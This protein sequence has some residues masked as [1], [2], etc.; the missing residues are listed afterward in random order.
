[1]GATV[2]RVLSQGRVRKVRI[3][4]ST[5]HG[6]WR[7]GRIRLQTWP[8]DPTIGHLVVIDHD[9]VP[10]PDELRE[11]TDAAARAG[12]R[13]VRSGAL[14]PRAADA[15]ANVGY[16]AIDTLALLELDLHTP[17]TGSNGRTRRLHR[18]QHATA[19][20]IDRAAFGDVWGNDAA[21]LD[22]IRRATPGHRARRLDHDHRMAAFAITGVASRTAYFQRLAVHPAHQRR[23][24]GRTLVADAIAWAR[25]RRLDTMMVNTG[26]DN[27]A[28][29]ALYDAFEFR[30]LRDQL[31][32]AELRLAAVTPATA[33][34]A[35][36]QQDR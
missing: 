11:V 32:V 24:M 28:A 21:G 15:L 22:G 29:L 18:W 7:N 13:A 2:T 8:T 9:T 36:A 1:M 25:A 4:Q 19:A 12:A 10:S 5:V 14:F 23:G 27:A 3:R 33:P 20:A 31:T 17:A 30:V 34:G 35:P 26:V 6:V 16:V